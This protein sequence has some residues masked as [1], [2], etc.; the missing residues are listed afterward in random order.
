MKPLNDIGP[1]PPGWRISSS[2]VIVDPDI[3]Q[4]EPEEYDPLQDVEDSRLMVRRIDGTG[5]PVTIDTAWRIYRAEQ[6]AQAKEGR[7]S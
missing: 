4:P 5:K 1:P 3:E 6:R 7:Q 2:V